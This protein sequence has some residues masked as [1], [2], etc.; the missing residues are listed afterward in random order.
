M[1]YTTA[2]LLAIV[3]LAFLASASSKNINLEEKDSL[4]VV[5]RE[6]RGAESCTAHCLLLGRNGGS[7]KMAWYYSISCGAFLVCN[8]Y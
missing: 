6:K 5:H 3:L 2:L 8:C 4:E 7:C 1:K